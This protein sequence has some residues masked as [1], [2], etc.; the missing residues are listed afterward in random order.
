VCRDVIVVPFGGGRQASRS[1]GC[2]RAGLAAWH[3]IGA[4]LQTGACGLRCSWADVGC[5]SRVL[6]DSPTMVVNAACGSA[7]SSGRSHVS[8]T[9]DSRKASVIVAQVSV[10][11]CVVATGGVC[12][13]AVAG[14]GGR[15]AKCRC[16]PSGP[17]DGWQAIR[18]TDGRRTDRRACS[19][20]TSGSQSGAGEG[21]CSTA[22]GSGA[23]GTGSVSGSGIG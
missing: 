18:S 16:E 7:R 15:T 2:W 20:I 22:G 8:Q 6:T 10:A 1:A 21:I 3:A 13:D 11:D 17:L 14:Q 5:G 23:M 9:R 19:G 4:G 12:P